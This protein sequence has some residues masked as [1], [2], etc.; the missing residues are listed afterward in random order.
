E[1]SPTDAGQIAIHVKDNGPGLSPEI[2]SQLFQ[3]FVTTKPGNLGMGLP[4]ARRLAEQHGGKLE[5]I[6]SDQGGHF[7]FYLPV[8]NAA[9][10]S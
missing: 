7:V 4:I 1:M 9:A 2:L 10:V 8:P 6:A 5:N 3:P